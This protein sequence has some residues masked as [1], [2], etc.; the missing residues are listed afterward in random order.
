MKKKA[1][2][3][4]LP[5]IAAAVIIV[6][7]AAFLA[8]Q[9]VKT[10]DQKLS[11]GIS[12]C[13]TVETNL[14]FSC[15]RSVIEK[16]YKGDLEGFSKK[17]Q[18]DK[19]LS[20]EVKFANN[21]DISY[22]IFGTN[23]HTF[24]HAA[25]DFVAT[26]SDKDV[27]TILS[28][29][30]PNC[31]SGYTMGVYKRIALKKHFDEETLK[32]F[33]KVCQEGS[34]NQCAHE[35]GHNLHDKYSYSVLKVL[36]QLSR[37][38]YGLTYPEAYAYV[39]NQETNVDA[40]FVDCQKIMPDDNKLAQCYTGI[41]H[42]LFL[43]SEFAGDYKGQLDECAK[44]A[45]ENMDTCYGFLVYRIGINHAATSLLSNKPDDANEVC[46]K[47][48]VQINREDL[49]RHCYL[50]IGGGIGLWLDSYYNSVKVDDNNLVQV[51]KELLDFALLC[52][53]TPDDQKDN[54]YLGLLGT[55]FKKFYTDYGIY[56]ERLEKLLPTV[57]SDFEVVG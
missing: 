35:I 11:K 53:Q 55:K 49:K 40:P 56:S 13:N 45:Q 46:D 31:T 30:T 19:S 4:K 10:P 22:A 44:T 48:T 15:Y 42:N 21:K 26:Y 8:P 27:K 37:D 2:K 41:G 38:E 23:C 32:E 43:F 3:F 51:K 33:W 17:I 28:M 34:Q 57:S 52:E 14:R 6:A 5:L 16:S 24:Y 18:N 29:G 25:G 20:F 36:D 1:K 54:C 47:V 12:G 7:M 9:L 50:G 39:T